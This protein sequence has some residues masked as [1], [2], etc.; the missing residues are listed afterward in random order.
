M[1][2]VKSEYIQDIDNETLYTYAIK[3]VIDNLD[4]YSRVSESSD[5]SVINNDSYGIGIELKL[6]ENG[7]SIS[8]IH[9]SSQLYNTLVKKGDIIY[10]INNKEYN[11]Y[12]GDSLSFINN[13]KDSNNSNIKLNL[14]NSKN[15]KYE[16]NVKNKKYSKDK[17]YLEVIDGDYLYYKIDTFS[18]GL[19][20]DIL[21]S[22]INH[23]SLNYNP[24]GIVID[25]R[26]NFG[27]TL[28]EAISLSNYFLS[29]QGETLLTTKYKDKSKVYKVMNKMDLFSNIK[30][31]ILVNN[32][33]A[34]AAEIFSGTM[35]HFNRAIII[36]EKTYGKGVGQVS[37]KINNKSLGHITSFEYFIGDKNLKVNNIG[38]KPDI[39]FSD[40]NKIYIESKNDPMIKSAISIIN[41][42]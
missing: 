36:G 30:T 38:I 12:N 26:D 20:V 25:L 35:K 10:S 15:K 41:N 5:L 17:Y 9:K 27:G 31:I 34:S 7:L 1:N 32:N 11:S 16:I 18:K 23:T 4:K 28:D 8:R 13:I 21:K 33:S 6:E 42:S 2:I 3:G 24:K 29:A 19:S 39:I 14:I 37:Y 22:F 40:D